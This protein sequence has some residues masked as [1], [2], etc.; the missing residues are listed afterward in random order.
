M[1]EFDSAAVRDPSSVDVPAELKAQIEEFMGRYPDKHSAVLPALQAAQE[2]HG[3]CSP[4]AMVQVAAVM[5]VTPAYLESIATFYDMLR[6]RPAGKHKIMVCTNISCQLRGA[7]EVLTALEQATGA[8]NGDISPDGEF[9]LE[10]FEC[11]GACNLAPMA[12]VNGR[13]RGPLK[14]ED[15]QRIVD[16][17]RG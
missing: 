13:Y 15:A 10:P 1:S 6:L 11:L 2:L 3:W 17:L 9:Q 12:S 7:G 8:V 5:Q 14:P 4:E 16:E